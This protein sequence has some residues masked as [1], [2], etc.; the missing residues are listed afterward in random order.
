MGGERGAH[1]LMGRHATASRNIG[2]GQPAQE[3]LSRAGS[4]ATSIQKDWKLHFNQL[5]RADR[6][7]RQSALRKRPQVQLASD[8]VGKSAQLNKSDGS[9]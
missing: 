4:L 9:L 5:P 2:F 6:G 8:N 7:Y 3:L 1:G